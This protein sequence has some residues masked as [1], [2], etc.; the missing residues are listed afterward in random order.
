ML[1]QMLNHT[2]QNDNGDTGDIEKSLAH[3]RY[4]FHTFS[5]LEHVQTKYFKS[6]TFCA[7]VYHNACFQ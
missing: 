2:V 5:I 7:H 3:Y 4:R 6:L 1:E